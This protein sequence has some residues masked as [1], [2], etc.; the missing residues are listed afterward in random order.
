MNIHDLCS[1]YIHNTTL[2]S[3]NIHII[4]IH[5]LNIIHKYNFQTRSKVPASLK[6]QFNTL[7]N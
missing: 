2:D 3:L 1:V 6:I 4:Y 5:I 7:T